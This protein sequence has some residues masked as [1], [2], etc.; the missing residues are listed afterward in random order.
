MDT[1]TPWPPSPPGGQTHNGYTQSQ[2]ERLTLPL[3]W[4]DGG[5][6]VLVPAAARVITHV[7]HSC[8]FSSEKK[9]Q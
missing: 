4:E 1:W 8:P 9:A 2:E 5:A 6:P 7:P 3:G